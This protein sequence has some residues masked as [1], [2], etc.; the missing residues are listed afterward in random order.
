ME[1]NASTLTALT[2]GY[3]AIFNETLAGYMPS[4]R[5]VA[6]EIE[7]MNLEENHQWLGANPTMREWVGD[8]I[9]HGLRGQNW[10]IINKPWEVTIGIARRDIE[11]D[12]LGKYRPKIQMLAMEPV[13]HQD[14]LI[15][16]LRK[17]GA[18]TL[19]YDG[20]YFYDTD[21]AEG[22]SGAQSNKLTGTGVSISQIETDFNA[23]RAALLNFK[24]D[25]GKPY[26]PSS[27]QFQLQVTAP[28]GLLGIFEKLLNASTINNN[29]N[30]LKG[31]ATLKVDNNLTDANDWYLDVIGPF[32]IRPFIMQIAKRPN[33]VALDDP[34]NDTVFKRA[35]FQY[36]AE[37]DYNA[38]YAFWQ[39]SVLTTN[40]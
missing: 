33:F 38:G 35:E 31:A 20:Q 2:K 9:V 7:S 23:A 1:V 11:F 3:R 28:P 37:G 34:S 21:H 16:N 4:W 29:E 19:C 17:T 12:A 26:F 22:D 18:A 6:M 15:S 14:E 40:A 39:T 36:S 13:R 30:T 27:A 10:I 25:R 32:P 8:K 24:N 5:T